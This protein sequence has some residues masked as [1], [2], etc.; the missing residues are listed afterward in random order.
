MRL[1]RLGASHR[2]AAWWR[3]VQ[4]HHSWLLAGASARCWQPTT[5]CPDPAPGL[6]RRLTTCIVTPASSK[7][8]VESTC[9][10]AAWAGGAAVAA[11]RTACRAGRLGTAAALVRES[12]A[13][14]E[15]GQAHWGDIGE[16]A[17]G[18][19][20]RRGQAAAAAAA[21]AKRP[22]AP[23]CRRLHASATTMSMVRQS[24]QT[25]CRGRRA[26]SPDLKCCPPSAVPRPGSALLTCCARCCR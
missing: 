25:A 1:A 5:T 17:K 18:A 24:I 20:E 16:V 4:Q 26:R 15:V 7:R 14:I 22:R 23:P 3:P 19:A 11:T 2:S 6:R 9:S 21:A 8:E 10:S 13:G 12:S